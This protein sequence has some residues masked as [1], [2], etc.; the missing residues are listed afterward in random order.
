MQESDL[1]EYDKDVIMNISKFYV[2]HE[3]IGKVLS[4]CYIIYFQVEKTIIGT[5]LVFDNMLTLLVIN[6]GDEINLLD[7]LPSEYELSEGIR[8]FDL[9][10]QIKDQ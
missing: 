6:L 4:S 3:Y 9:I 5:N 10:E 1:G 8:Y 2:L 7:S